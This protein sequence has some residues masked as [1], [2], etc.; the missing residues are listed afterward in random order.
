MKTIIYILIAALGIFTLF[1]C[2]QDD[3]LFDDSMS[4][5]GFYNSTA[6]VIEYDETLSGG[7]SITVA[8]LIT[9]ANTSACEI[10]FDVDTEGID[11]PAIEGIDFETISSKTITVAEGESYYY[12]TLKMIDNDEY[13]QNGNK[14]FKLTITNNSLGYDLTANSSI[15]ITI[16][17]DDHPLGWLFGDYNGATTETAN[18]STSYDISIS[19]VDGEPTKIM[20][21]GMAGAA[22]GPGLIDPYYILGTVSDDYSTVSIAAGQE[23]ESWGYGATILTAWEDDNGE[24]EE[25][26]EIIG[27]IDQTNGVVITL[28]QQYTFMITD[29]TNEGL[30]L[31]WSWN[32]DT[33]TNS[34]TSIWTKQ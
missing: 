27:T 33:E 12:L 30:G 18:G 24:G 7:D 8:F 20:I 10:T 6:S 9:S 15:T 11:N 26:D 28:Y 22:Y 13:D 25:T 29:G 34:A 3:I 21:Y 1:S 5:V 17:D 19:V 32:S 2:E 14:S 23:W 16:T 4:A 31:Q